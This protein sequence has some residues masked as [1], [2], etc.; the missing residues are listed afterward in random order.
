MFFFSKNSI[1][2]REKHMRCGIG[3]S[4]EISSIDVCLEQ[5]ACTTHIV[6][7]L[8]FA[9]VFSF[10]AN[11]LPGNKCSDIARDAINNRT[12]AI[13][14]R[15]RGGQ[16]SNISTKSTTAQIWSKQFFIK[17]DNSFCD[18]EQLKQL[19]LVS[20][21]SLQERKKKKTFSVGNEKIYFF[22]P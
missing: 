20:L 4:A 12:K 7:L 6:L 22:S 18:K 16:N 5:C 8:A 10:V 19:G 21:L 9:I 2:F 1:Q 17:C 14:L 15:A 11:I 13:I 3:V